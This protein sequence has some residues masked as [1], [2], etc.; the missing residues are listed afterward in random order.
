MQQQRK[1]GSKGMRA[2]RVSDQDDALAAPGFALAADAARAAQEWL[3]HLR[4]ARRAS[5][6]TLLAYAR[7]LAHFST[8]MSEHL[9]S[10]PGLAELARLRPADFRA[11][12]AAGS[13]EGASAR[14]RARRL[15]AV[16]GYFRWLKRQHGV[17]NPALAVVRGPKLEKGLPHPV[18]Q[19]RAL[20]LL[21][22][23]LDDAGDDGSRAAPGWVRARNAA[24]LALLYGCGLRISE[25]LGLTAAQ[26]APLL[27]QGEGF[28]TIRGKG[29]KE[30]MVPV[31]PAA[32]ALLRRYADA[33]PFAL[34]PQQAFFRGVRGGALSPRIIQQLMQRLRGYLALPETA[35]PHAL[36]HSFATHL[37]AGGADLRAI[38]ELLG[39][40]S[41]STTQV[42]TEVDAGA[43][44]LAHQRCHPRA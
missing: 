40:A 23:A 12:L 13:R 38:Q 22:A 10:A 35:T 27:A 6:H 18:E 5:T 9:G 15:S 33:C 1:Q 29:Q 7:D 43:L 32:V 25:A 30:R 17:D 2:E 26:V 20:E 11:W 31:L 8:F 14:T 39:H 4:D 21:E 24:V 36:R 16:R 37:L 42:Y 34:A 3:T 41:L 44:R 19:Q 28:L